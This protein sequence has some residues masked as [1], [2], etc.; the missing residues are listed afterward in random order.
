MIRGIPRC[1]NSS[2]SILFPKRIWFGG[3]SNSGPVR[4]RKGLSPLMYPSD[5]FPKRILNVT[6]RNMREARMPIMVID[7]SPSADITPALEMSERL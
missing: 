7:F 5:I 3:H 1:V 6:L 2:G 4:S